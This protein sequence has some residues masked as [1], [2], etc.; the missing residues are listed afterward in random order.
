VQVRRAYKFRA[1]PTRPQESGERRHVAGSDGGA[2]RT[3]TAARFARSVRKR[4]P[5]MRRPAA[6]FHDPGLKTTICMGLG[7]RSWKTA[8]AP[9]PATI[10]SAITVTR[11]PERKSCTGQSR[12]RASAR[13]AVSGLT[14]FGRGSVFIQV[15]FGGQRDPQGSCIGYVASPNAVKNSLAC[16]LRRVT[17]TTP[18]RW[19]PGQREILITGSRG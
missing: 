17:G 15:K 9:A 11:R 19:P 5:D 7:P 14:A 18:V 12:L 1:Y 16:T 6:I 2:V 3:H 10:G 13:R 8:T 4:R